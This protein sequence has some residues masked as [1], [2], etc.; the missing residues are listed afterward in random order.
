[1]DSGEEDARGRA[2]VDDGCIGQEKTD[3]RLART[4]E[5]KRARPCRLTA[6]VSAIVVMVALLVGVCAG[7]AAAAQVTLAWDANTEPD[8]S[9]YNLYLG[10]S[11]GAYGAPINVGNVNTFTVTGLADGKAYFFVMTAY[12]T[13][14]NESG[15]SN[16]VPYTTP[17]T[18]APLPEINLVGNNARIVSGDTAPSTSDHTYSAA[19]TSPR[20]RSRAP[21][22]SRTRAPA[23]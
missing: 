15:Y 5:T 19:W 17:G 11:S 4:H 1:M 14:G 2:S 23:P 18:A 8:V 6:I 22:R 12:D 9:G 13:F 16:E 7:Q 10:T 20:A 3:M 21:S